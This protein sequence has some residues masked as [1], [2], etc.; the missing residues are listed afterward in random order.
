MTHFRGVEVE[1]Q[2]GQVT[3]RLSHTGGGLGPGSEP[4]WG[5]LTMAV[6]RET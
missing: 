2:R 3:C 6:D 4:S 1:G 5:T